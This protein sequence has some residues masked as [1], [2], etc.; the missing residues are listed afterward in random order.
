QVQAVSEW[1]KQFQDLSADLDLII[2]LLTGLGVAIAVSSIL[3][4]T[5]LSVT[6]RIVE[7][8]IVRANSWSQRNVVQLIVCEAALVGAAGGLLGVLAGWAA[9][10][11]INAI[12]AD[13]VHL[14]ASGLLLT[15]SLLFAVVVG[16][17]G[18]FYPA[19]RAARLSPME[20]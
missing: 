13:R 3:N 8:G 4:T 6:E 12:W 19:L 11:V 15:F 17:L 2:M 9:T 1:S 18:G 7:F 20:A 5:L 10:L 16:M 14:Y